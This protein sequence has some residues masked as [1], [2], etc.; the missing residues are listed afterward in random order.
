MN[1]FYIYMKVII[2]P[3]RKLYFNKCEVGIQL[4]VFFFY[5][6][7]PAVYFPNIYRTICQTPHPSNFKCFLCHI[8]ILNIR[9]LTRE[10]NLYI[11][12]KLLMSL[13]IAIQKVTYIIFYNS[14]KSLLEFQFSLLK[15]DKSYDFS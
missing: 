11:D 5:P 10:Y 13:D 15:E 9:L 4:W 2:L 6:Q 12:Y 3:F 7:L 1:L 14:T 8:C